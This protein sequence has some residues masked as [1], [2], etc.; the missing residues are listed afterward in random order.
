VALAWARD[1]PQQ[2]EKL[3]LIGA[4]PCFTRRE[5]WP[6]AIEARVL[7]DFANALACNREGTLQRFASLQAEGERDSKA[8]SRTLR[9]AAAQS[10]TSMLTLQRGLD[11]L[12]ETDVRGGLPCVV[13]ATLV[14]HGERDVLSPL[15]TGVQLASAL[16]HAR[17]CI[18]EGAAHAP[19]IAHTDAVADAIEAFFT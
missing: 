19:F 3:V 1:I 8:V 10:D 7:H 16:P 17:L 11:V 15:A 14:V 2:V 9:A 5:D 12:L 6:H 13:Q 18:I 4:T